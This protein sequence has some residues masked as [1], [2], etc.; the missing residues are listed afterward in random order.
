MVYRHR[1]AADETPRS[2]EEASLLG[3]ETL[4]S[5]L[6][7]RFINLPPAEVDREIEEVLRRVCEV[8]GVDL[9]ALWNDG[10]T[11]PSRPPTSTAPAGIC[12][13][14]CAA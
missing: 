12:S 6:S 1:V 3:F 7:S 4:I 9:A 13:P 11:V 2:K 5:E 10:P 14:R 8:L